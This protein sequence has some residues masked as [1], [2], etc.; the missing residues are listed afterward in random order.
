MKLASVQKVI[1]LTPIEGAD[2]IE[3]ATVLGW[4]IVIKKGEYQVGALCTYIQIDTIVP[5]RPEFEFLR[6]R[7]FRVRTIKLRK[8]ISQGLIVPLPSGNWNEGDDVTELLGVTKY[9]KQDNNPQSYEKPRIP[10]SGVKRWIYLFKYNFLFKLFPFLLKES[11][12][13]FPKE[14][15]GIT[16]EERIQNMPQVLQQYAG[17]LFV[18]SYKLDGSSITIIHNKVRGKSKYRICSRRFELHD[19]K[20]D[21]YTTFMETNFALEI[22]KL[23]TYFATDDVIV[24]GEAIGKFNGNHHNLSRNEIRLFN[25]YVN[26]KRLNQQKFFEVCLQLNIPHCPLFKELTMQY[27]LEDILKISE[28]KDVIN[29][30]VEAE[31]LVWRCVDDN[32]SFKVINNKFLLKNDE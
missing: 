30:K 1:K 19:K 31:G 29:P 8:Q 14:L 7:K 16:D 2:L 13:P 25:I 9:E 28:I 11:R 27:S 15:V 17:K 26:G 4:E 3:T 10:K 18:V 23:V 12:T 32:L 5:E 24:Q 22:Q 6:P 21:W 20:N